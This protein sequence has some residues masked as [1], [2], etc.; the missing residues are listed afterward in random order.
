MVGGIEEDLLAAVVAE[1]DVL[2]DVLASLTHAEW[3][4]PTPSPG[5]AVRDQ[6]RHLAVSERAAGLALAGRAH[7]VFGP[8][9]VPGP[10]P[11]D[12]P[13]ELLGA[14]RTARRATVAGLRRLDPR[15]RVVWGA[16]PMSARSFA[17]A[18]LME[19]WAHGLDCFAAV[20][21]P[22]VDTDRLRHV[23]D[24]GYCTLPYAFAVTGEPVPADLGGLAL[25]L[26]AP[27]GAKW[28]F[29]AKPPTALV[30]GAAGDWCRLVTRRV[31][32]DRS[33]LR[34]EGAA[35]VAALR[36]ARAYLADGT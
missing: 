9:A 18:R 36:V 7:E 17:Q 28:L 35:A 1:H 8:D 24:L 2:D 20:H 11:G 21:V 31:A 5:W 6:V 27:D 33:T 13:A 4:M 3:G 14:W 19:T 15:D 26:L 10:A 29:G 34:A 22:A 12:D 25:E 32:L 16:G 30:Q 23:A